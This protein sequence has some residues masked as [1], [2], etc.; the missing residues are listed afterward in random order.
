MLIVFRTALILNN[1]LTFII[2]SK[3][4]DTSRIPGIFIR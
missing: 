3:A 4:G 2:Q 1:I